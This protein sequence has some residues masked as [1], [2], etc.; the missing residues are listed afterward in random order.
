MKTFTI[1]EFVAHVATMQ[2]DVKLAEEAAVVAGCKLVQR[3]AKRILGHPQP[4][5]PP[6]QPETIE[7]KARGDT[8]LLETGKMKQSIEMAAPFREGNTVWGS[9][10]SNS[11][12]AV[13]QEL[14]TSRIPPRPFISLAA[15]GQEKAVYELTG[16]IVYKAMINGGRNFHALQEVLHLLHMAGE[17]LKDALPGEDDDETSLQRDL[18]GGAANVRAIARGIGKL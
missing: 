1:G 5:W 14:G 7:R 6:L 11:D 8:P 13:Y 10:G 9:V 2:A 15:A 17:N 18:K 4:D 16:R 12:I 3:V